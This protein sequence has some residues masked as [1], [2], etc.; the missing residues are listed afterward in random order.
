MYQCHFRVRLKELKKCEQEYTSIGP[1]DPTFSFKS[2]LKRAIEVEDDFNNQITAPG[3]VAHDEPVVLPSLSSRDFAQSS[4]LA[5]GIIGQSSHV[6]LTSRKK[7]NKKYKKQLKKRKRQLEKSSDSL[8]YKV[9]RLQAKKHVNVADPI[10]TKLK[11]ESL[12]VASTGF[13]G[14]RETDEE[15]VDDTMFLDEFMQ[16]NEDFE[17]VHYEGRRVA[18]SLYISCI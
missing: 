2:L 13:I 5:S 11:T 9:P 10:P 16:E 15:K 17:I 4:T 1:A 8:E 7:H 6:P 12:P 3:D 18:M 14:K